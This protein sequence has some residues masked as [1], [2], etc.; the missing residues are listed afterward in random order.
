MD[1]L[2]LLSCLLFRGGAKQL[3]VRRVHFLRK[4]GIG[5]PTL[6]GVFV[7]RLHTSSAFLTLY[8]PQI[9]TLIT[10]LC[11]AMQIILN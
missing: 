7:H 8:C 11:Y 3:L 4:G 5:N 6:C 1:G 10:K 2:A 9:M